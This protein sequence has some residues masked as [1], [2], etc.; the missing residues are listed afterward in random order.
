MA[1]GQPQRNIGHALPLAQ[2]LDTHTLTRAY[3]I[4]KLATTGR[5]DEAIAAAD[6][7]I[8]DA[9]ST[10]NPGALAFALLA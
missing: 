9:E 2:G 1:I 10:R 5:E 4:V 7:L 6:G 8:N 3:L